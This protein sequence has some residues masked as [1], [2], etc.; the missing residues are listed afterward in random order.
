VLSQAGAPL[1]WTNVGVASLHNQPSFSM[2]CW[3]RVSEEGSGYRAPASASGASNVDGA[4]DTP[5]VPE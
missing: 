2:C 1:S 3:L 4:G 5:F